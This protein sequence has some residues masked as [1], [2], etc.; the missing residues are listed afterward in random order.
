M[1]LW[2]ES[3]GSSFLSLWNVFTGH[4]YQLKW[5]FIICVAFSVA[6]TMKWDKRAWEHALLFLDNLS[7]CEC[8]LHG[9]TWSKLLS[10][11]LYI[12]FI[13]VFFS[14]PSL[15]ELYLIWFSLINFY[16]IMQILIYWTVCL[17]FSPCA[18]RVLTM[19][20]CFGNLKWRNN[21]R[22]RLDHASWNGFPSKSMENLIIELFLYM[23]G[24]GLSGYPSEISSSRV[25]HLVHQ[26][27]LRLS[28]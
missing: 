19:R 26:I 9:H 22:G 6:K 21:L 28:L 18:S 27:F 16:I 2:S 3:Q 12:R 7:L 4:H 15:F 11:V 23:V 17:F 14:S 1:N 8:G 24:S 10:L 5:T 20:L 25:W 13:F